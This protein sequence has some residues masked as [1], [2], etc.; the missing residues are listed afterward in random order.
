[1]YLSETIDWFGAE[2]Y[3]NWVR[4]PIELKELV[5]D[6]TTHPDKY[7]KNTDELQKFMVQKD[8][9]FFERLNSLIKE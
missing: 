8:K 4:S 2:H 1:M 6:I 5:T 7:K 3:L 9:E